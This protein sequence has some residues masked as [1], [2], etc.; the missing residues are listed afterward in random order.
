M[1][2][3]I[4]R[5]TALFG[6]FVRS[7]Q[8]TASI[9]ATLLLPVFIMGGMTLAD[10]GFAGQGRMQLDQAL[11]AGAQVSMINVND[12]DQ[13]EEATLAALGIT[14]SGVLGPDGLC[15]DGKIC[16]S[17]SSTCQCTAGVSAVCTSLCPGTDETPSAF[18]NITA[19]RRHA[20]IVLGDREVS[21]QITVQTR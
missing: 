18:V 11:R 21:S 10:V 9:E 7:I 1:M 3:F 15:Q 2:H 8:G 13:I 6:A 17:V 19:R 16:I 4:T 20:G 5:L 12:V 14:E